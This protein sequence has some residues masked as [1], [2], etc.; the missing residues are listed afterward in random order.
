MFWD[1]IQFK[2]CPSSISGGTI[3]DGFLP[4]CWKSQDLSHTRQVFYTDLYPR[5]PWRFIFIL[6]QR[7]REIALPWCLRKVRGQFV[8]AASLLLHWG[9]VDWTQA[10]SLGD[11]HL[12]PLVISPAW[13]IIF[14][15]W[16][17][18]ILLV[19]SAYSF[20]LVPFTGFSDKHHIK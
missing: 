12:L 9:P 14:K 20:F 13:E 7:K 4:Q 16:K 3:L 19:T 11:R 17:L 18:L 5:P 15:I 6:S 1:F 8:G 2:V 10:T